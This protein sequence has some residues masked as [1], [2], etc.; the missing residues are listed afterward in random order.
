MELMFKCQIGFQ[1]QKLYLS[2]CA[3]PSSIMALLYRITNVI[4]LCD[5][6]PLVPHVF[7]QRN[8]STTLVGRRL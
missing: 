2:E 6:T 3:C 7:F 8:L 1:D 4:F 5:V